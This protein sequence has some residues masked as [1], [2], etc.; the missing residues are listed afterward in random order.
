MD[1]HKKNINSKIKGAIKTFNIIVLYIFFSF[2]FCFV[3]LL[4]LLGAVGP[5]CI[6]GTP[7]SKVSSIRIGVPKIQKKYHYTVQKF[8]EILDP[9]HPLAKTITLDKWKCPYHFIKLDPQPP[10]FVMYII[11]YHLF[12]HKSRLCSEY[13]DM[14]KYTT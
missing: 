14:Y 1:R 3:L 12:I 2:I 7:I 4:F 6:L 10:F 5:I 13:Q 8:R 11:T 9:E